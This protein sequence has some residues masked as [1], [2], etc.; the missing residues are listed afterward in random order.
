MERRE[1]R[2]NHPLVCLLSNH[3][4]LLGEF[5]RKLSQSHFTVKAFRLRQVFFHDVNQLGI[6]TAKV[7]V[8]D[9]HDP[10]APS[11]VGGLV[12]RFPNSHVIVLSEKFTD[13]T[14]FPLLELGVRGLLDYSEASTH[15][16]EAISMVAKGE[17]WVEQQLFSRFVDSFVQKGRRRPVKPQSTR[18]SSRE[19]EVLECL[20][21]NLSNKD[22]AKKLSIT[23][24]TVKF[25][26]SNLLAKFN[27]RRRVDLIMLHL[28]D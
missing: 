12:N 28:H 1:K 15:L 24:R 4:L 23:E 11:L 17:Y 7:Y 26:V 20:L 2:N 21:K 18:L 14:A 19:R 3:P 13:S 22:I 8:V 5:A 27:V 6:P 16:P 10:F 9:G 25:H